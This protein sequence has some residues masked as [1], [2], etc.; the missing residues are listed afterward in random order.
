[1]ILHD[2]LLCLCISIDVWKLLFQWIRWSFPDNVYVEFRIGLVLLVLGQESDNLLLN[3][4]IWGRGFAKW[5]LF[6]S[7]TNYYICMTSIFMFR[8]LIH[9]R[10][11]I[12]FFLILWN[13]R[14]IVPTRSFVTLSN[15]MNTC[16][17][18][19]DSLGYMHKNWMSKMKIGKHVCCIIARFCNLFVRSHPEDDY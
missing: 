8:L 2:I 16:F 18:D 4:L 13:L 9:H 7:I 12:K 19:D 6:I 11:I 15:L 3:Y 10:E 17:G 5:N 14:V 1:M